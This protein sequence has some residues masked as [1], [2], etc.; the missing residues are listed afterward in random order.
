M[1]A[2]CPILKIQYQ[3]ALKKIFPQTK[4]IIIGKI[5]ILFSERQYLI[6]TK[7]DATN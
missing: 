7:H 4:V 6:I 2:V 1:K 5:K 3:P